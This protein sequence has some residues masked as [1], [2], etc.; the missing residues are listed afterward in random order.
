MAQVTADGAAAVAHRDRRFIRGEAGRVLFI[1]GVV[2]CA[3]LVRAG[4]AEHPSARRAGVER[5][6][7][8]LLLR[9][10]LHDGEIGEILTILVHC[11]TVGQGRGGRLD[12]VVV[13]AG[14]EFFDAEAQGLGVGIVVI[15]IL[16]FIEQPRHEATLHFV[17]DRAARRH[18][19]RD[20]IRIEGVGADRE[21]GEDQAWGEM[22]DPGGSSKNQSKAGICCNDLNAGFFGPLFTVRSPG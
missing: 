7:H 1:E 11:G 6:P 12:D 15:V 9:A 10:D 20:F 5:Q 13:A 22:H 3:G 18:I 19:E 17:Q 2:R 4:R 21:A 14:G 8:L 16:G